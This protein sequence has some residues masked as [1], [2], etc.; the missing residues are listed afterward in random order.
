MFPHGGYDLHAPHVSPDGRTVL[1][2]VVNE[3]VTAPPNG[4][5]KALYSVRMNG[6]HPQHGPAV[7]IRRLRLRR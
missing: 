7:P 4:V 5:R 1:F 2:V 6:T 3:S